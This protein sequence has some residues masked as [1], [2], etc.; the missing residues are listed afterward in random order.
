MSCTSCTW[1]KASGTQGKAGSECFGLLNIHT[2]DDS[3][4]VMSCS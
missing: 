3:L 1:S 4:D 2:L